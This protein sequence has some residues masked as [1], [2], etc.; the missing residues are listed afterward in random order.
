VLNQNDSKLKLEDEL[1][2]DY[3]KKLE[4]LLKENENVDGYFVGDSVSVL[5]TS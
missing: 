5:K 1:L 3:F 4:A 2:P